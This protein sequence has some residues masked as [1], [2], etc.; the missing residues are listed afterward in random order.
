MKRN[1]PLVTLLVG[2]ALGVVLLVAT[3]LATPSS[4]LPASYSTAA[5]SSAAPA[6]SSPAPAESSESPEQSAEPAQSAPAAAPSPAPTRTTPT[7]ADFVGR[8]GGGGG[9]VAVAVHG[10]KAIAY[11]CNG[12]T[13][14][15]WMRGKVENGKLTLTGKNKAKLT[16][17]IHTGTVT[18][19][20]EAHG[21]D[22]SF[23][24][25]TVSKSSSKSSGLYQATA[26]VQGKTIKA[27]WIVQN[28]GTQIGSLETDELGE[29]AVT[30]PKLD[31]ATMTA[32]IGNV[33]LHA[34]PVSGVT[35]SGF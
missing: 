25:S 14:E 23:S 1:T 17:S 9:S 20:V 31:V 16:A 13:V 19:D 28:D 3:M 27:G 21:T 15:G 6:P 33:V 29:N 35:G 10:D 7:R 24:V 22:Y 30:A 4:A 12:S 11:V 26:V 8:V 5:A 2:A 32:R 34:V 18:G